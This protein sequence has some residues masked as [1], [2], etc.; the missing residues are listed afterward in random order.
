MTAMINRTNY[1]IYFIDYFD[2][3]L[4]EKSQKELF[5]FLKANADLKD[6]FDRFVRLAEC[7]W[8]KAA[9]SD[10]DQSVAAREYSG[11]WGHCCVQCVVHKAIQVNQATADWA[12]K[13]SICA[14]E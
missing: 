3:R 10:C 11:R 9:S 4:D 14:S 13:S 8:G 2:G 7:A 12:N 1:E 6:E 5:A